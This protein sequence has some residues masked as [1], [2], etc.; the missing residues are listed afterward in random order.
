MFI[1]DLISDLHVTPD[2]EFNWEGQPTAL[3]CLV[4]GD[5][6]RDRTTLLKTLRHLSQFYMGTFFIDGNDEHRDY[7]DVI[8]DSYDELVAEINKIPGVIYLH[9][10]VVVI[11]GIAFVAANGW[12]TYNFNPY[13]NF[14]ESMD[15]FCEYTG[16]SKDVAIELMVKGYHD[17]AYLCNTVDKLQRHPDVKSIVMISHTVPTAELTNHDTTLVDDLRYN[18]L[19]NNHL[20]EALAHD[21]AG[22]IKMWCFGHY[23]YAIDRDIDGIQYISNP[24]GRPGSPWCNDPYYP[25]RIEIAI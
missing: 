13:L 20:R 2:M 19:G 18:C 8:G 22:K 17:A 4:V 15:W 11:D 7:Y 5:V 14:D 24:R 23:H 6:A 9:N 10:N 21:T 1:F 12:W 16:V 3:Y 25:K